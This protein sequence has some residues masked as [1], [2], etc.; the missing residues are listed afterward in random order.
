MAVA[1]STADRILDTSLGVF[2]RYGFQKTS[3]QNIAAAAGISRAAVYLHFAN[4]EEVFRAGSLRAHT[5]ALDAVDAALGS[6]ADI[7]AGVQAALT[8]YF[9]GLMSE[10][11]ASP[12]GPELF[13]ANRELIGDVVRHTRAALLDRLTLALDAADARGEIAL[14]GADISGAQLATLLVATA[15]GLKHDPLA[16]VSL[17][18]G[19][20]MQLRAL[21]VGIA[22]SRAAA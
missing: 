15:E 14:A 17:A 8:A 5:A 18:E 1:P 11:A 12:H 10:I 2:C 16:G 9:D 3:M 4:K 13:D 7:F 6:P 20:G 22:A 19:I 21:R